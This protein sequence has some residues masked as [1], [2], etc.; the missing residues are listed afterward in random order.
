MGIFAYFNVIDQTKYLARY[1]RS[2]C[3]DNLTGQCFPA[4]KGLRFGPYRSIS[5]RVD[6]RDGWIDI[7]VVTQGPIRLPED[8]TG[9]VNYSVSLE[10]DRAHFFAGFA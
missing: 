10:T 4:P 2:E 6:Q 1:L 5:G 8:P 7:V 3:R 9:M